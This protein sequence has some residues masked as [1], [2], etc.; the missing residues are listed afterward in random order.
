MRK[1]LGYDKMFG[2]ASSMLLSF[3][4]SVLVPAAREL[5]R[6]V[7]STLKKESRFE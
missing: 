4:T 1:Q 3:F 5:F 2:L 6:K 7:E